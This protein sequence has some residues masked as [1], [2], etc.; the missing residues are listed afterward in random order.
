LVNG[1][2]VQSHQLPGMERD[3]GVGSA[4]VIAELDF[5]DPRRQLSTTVPTWPRTNPSSG[6]SWSSATT[7]SISMSAM[8]N[9]LYGT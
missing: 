2:V 1:F 6:K 8:A 5:V 9:F 4:V 3:H 7:E